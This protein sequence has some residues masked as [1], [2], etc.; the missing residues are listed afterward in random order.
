LEREAEA[1]FAEYAAAR[2]HHL[3]RTAFLLCG[4]QTGAQDLAQETLTSLCRVWPRVRRMDAVDAYARR[5]LINTFFRQQRKLSRDRA[6]RQALLAD[7]TRA[8]G[9]TSEEAELRLELL[10]ALDRLGNRSRA[11][12]VLRYWD[13]M[14]VQDT[15]DA[16][17]C[18][19]GTVKS[20]TSRALVRLRELLGDSWRGGAPL[21]HDESKG[22]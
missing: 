14:S 18:S 22:N 7:Q 11:V 2:Q 3:L 15:A 5:T 8:V 6:A 17:G 1:E 16:L 10:A 12:L 13:D 20:Q 21:A 4:D 19:V 9:S